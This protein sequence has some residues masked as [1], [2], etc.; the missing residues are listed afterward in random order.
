MRV[1][2]YPLLIASVLIIQSCSDEKN[3]ATVS[4]T[5]KKQTITFIMATVQKQ[6]PQFAITLPGELKPFEQVNIYP[7]IKG[8]VKKLYVDRGSYV[9]KGQL[10]A[11]LEAPEVGQQY[12]AMRS[13][14]GTSYQKFLFS[15]QSYNRLKEAAKKNGAVATIELERAYAQYLGDSA[16]YSSSRSKASASGQIHNYLRITAPFSGVITGRFI[17]EGALVGDNGVNGEPLFQLAQQNKLRLTVAI[18]EKQV[19]SLPPGTKAQFT[20]IDLPGKIFTASLS[21][22]SG[23]LD[24]RSRSVIAEFDIDN[25]GTELRAG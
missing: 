23:A 4:V 18:P 6:Q 8:F 17:S 16:A 9:R 12:A 5:E 24:V 20:V 7:K 14:I 25:T 10:L 1:F 22:N 15:K 2:I 11:Q 21:R 19:Q 13:S 3:E